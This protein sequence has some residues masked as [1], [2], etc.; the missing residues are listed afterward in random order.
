MV[1]LQHFLSNGNTL[2]AT[3][4]RKITDI[5]SKMFMDSHTK[6][7]S[8]FLD[9]LNELIATHSEDLGDW[10]YVLCARLLNKLGTDLLGS[11][12][13]K[14]HK[15]LDVVREC[16]PGE[17]LLP[18][19]LRFLTDPT[20]T[21]NSRVKVATLN[22]ITQIADTAEPSAFNSSAGSALAR[23]L[24]WTNDAKSQDVRRH[25][26]NA[27]IALYNLNTPQVTM[28]L[29]DL[30]KCYQEM[31]LPLVQNHLRRSSGTS[32]PASPGTPPPRVPHS[33]ART[34]LK[35]EMDAA[36]DNL[37]PEE[38][39]KSL[40]RTT[41]EIQNYGFERLER[42]TTSKDSGISNMADVEERMEGLALSNSGRS[43]SVSSPTQRGRSVSNM[44]VNGSNDTIAGDLILPQENN[45]YKTHGSSPDSAKGPEV[46][47]NTMRILQSDVVPDVEKV[48]AL[49]EFQLYVRD[50]DIPYMKQNFKKLLKTLL[51]SLLSDN[52]E[53]QIEV[54]QVLIEMLKSSEL[55][56]CFSN[57]VELIVLKVLNAH[58]FDDQK[59]D[60]AS[61]GNSGR[62]MVLRV[63]EKCAATI[64]TVLPPD[65]IIQMVSS[66]ITTE[67]FPKN[68]G[69]IKM[70]HKVV[71]HWGRGAIEPHLSRVMPGL[72]KAYDDNEST[73]RKSAVFCMVAIHAAV[74][75]ETLKPHL[76]SLYGSKLKLLNIYIQRAQQASSQPAS[77]RSNN[78]N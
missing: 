17:Q 44:A 36:D 55:T 34:R 5:F 68:M 16:F 8:L 19:V 9:T 76:S 69:A 56:E 13:A 39:Y 7:F 60:A 20:Q 3:E 23:L 71:E 2:S 21:P 47:D 1:G 41:A 24:D 15:S 18:A 51:E 45:G 63:A 59:S 46:L 64:V 22:F 10:L 48:A 54:L 57:Y 38:V 30:P 4:L 42:A 61:G 12:Q 6:V 28:I 25:A 53:I 11:I 32:N 66:I 65:Q 26:Q 62:A 75:E 52:K 74:G 72:I 73:V 58:K 37:N 40:R 14:I 70:L 67:P 77:P 31:A 43:S 78:K 35:T 29:A 49:Q 27:V 33:P 50:G